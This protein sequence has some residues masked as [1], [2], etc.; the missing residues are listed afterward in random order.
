MSEEN[1]VKNNGNSKLIICIVI[2]GLI[3]AALLVVLIF[4]LGKDDKDNSTADSSSNIYTEE[5]V[6]GRKVLVNDENVEDILSSMEEKEYT[7]VGYYT[8]KMNYEWDFENGK[9]ASSNAY[10]Q[11]DPTNT[12]AVYF[13]IT[14]EDTGET[15]YESPIM[16]VGT[17]LGEV[18]LSKELPAGV[19]NCVCTYNLLDENNE[20]MSHLNVALTINIKN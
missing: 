2:I 9:S 20:P 1:K 7:P 12:Q 17:T 13:D 16:P 3:I 15:I 10:V 19:Y 4:V 6:N 18:I 14:L 8:A 11:N 5:T